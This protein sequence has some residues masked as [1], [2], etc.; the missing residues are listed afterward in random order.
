MV[1]P[2]GLVVVWAGYRSRSLS[3]V[4]GSAAAIVLPWVLVEAVYGLVTARPV[5][6]DLWV[7]VPAYWF[8]VALKLLL[9]GVAVGLIAIRSRWVRHDVTASKTRGNPTAVAGPR[10]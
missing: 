8:L 4:L 7:T 1:L 10:K 2:V 9:C 3:Q 5:A 6:H